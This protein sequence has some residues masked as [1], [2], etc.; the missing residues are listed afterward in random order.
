MKAG[1]L[2]RDDIEFINRCCDNRMYDCDTCKFMFSKEYTV[3][4][5]KD[6]HCVC[7]LR[8]LSLDEFEDIDK[9]V[10][11]LIEIKNEDIGDVL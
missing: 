5:S 8:F 3:S 11:M 1:K 7:D 4:P 2:T 6:I 10:E 9:F